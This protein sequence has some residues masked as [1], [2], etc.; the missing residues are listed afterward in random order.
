MI[1]DDPPRFLALVGSRAVKELPIRG[2]GNPLPLSILLDEL[3]QD[4]QFRGVGMTLL[5]ELRQLSTAIGSMEPILNILD[6]LPETGRRVCVC[7]SLFQAG[8]F[9]QLDKQVL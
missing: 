3:L 8:S 7:I 5:L 9:V 1:H 6:Q 2:R 4:F